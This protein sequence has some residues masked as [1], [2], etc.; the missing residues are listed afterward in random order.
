M[1]IAGACT[2]PNEQPRR[3]AS[4]PR[5]TVRNSETYVFDDALPSADG[6]PIVELVLR[7]VEL[8]CFRP[9]LN[10]M[11][12]SLKLGLADNHER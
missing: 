4:T 10:L 8:G 5:I 9:V 6:V 2:Y 1:V 7:K 3:I 12:R 11:D